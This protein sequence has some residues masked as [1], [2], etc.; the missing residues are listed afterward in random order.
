MRIL[1][2]TLMLVI[3]VGCVAKNKVNTPSA[4][5]FVDQQLRN[6]GEAITRDLAVLTGSQQNRDYGAPIG[7]GDLY[8]KV[9]VIWDGPIEGALAEISS[10]I[11]YK[12]E[13][14]GSAPAVPVL[15]H[16]KQIDRPA[17]TIIRDIGTQTGPQEGVALNEQMRVI[18]LVYKGGRI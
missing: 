18:R 4:D 14:E 15:V 6:S 12:L 10:K 11:G 8:S 9:T 3:S 2:I 7:A 1:L 17:L 5:S 16:I 13:I